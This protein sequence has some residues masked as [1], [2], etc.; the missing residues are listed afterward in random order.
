MIIKE[1]V[2]RNH[3]EQV[4]W[5]FLKWWVGEDAQVEYANSQESILGPAAR[6]PV[7]NL[8]AIDKLAWEPDTLET[9]NITVENMCS[10][11]QVPG[12]YI[13]GRY[14]ETA[15]LSVVNDNI[16]PI[17]T[18]YKQIRFI[19]DELTNKR[20]EFGLEERK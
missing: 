8:S 5:D 2:E 16:D 13:T 10:V 11:P 20:M 15:F 14:V 17:D 7:A 3:T 6:Y 4:A 18:L 19:N 1:T 9:V 12:S